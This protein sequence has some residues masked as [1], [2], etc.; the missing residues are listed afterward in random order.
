MLRVK[1]GAA[2]ARNLLGSVCPDGVN[3]VSFVDGH[4]LSPP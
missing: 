2:T 4:A 1:V 3:Y